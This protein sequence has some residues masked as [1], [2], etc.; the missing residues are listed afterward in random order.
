[1][2]GSIAAFLAFYYILLLSP[3]PLGIHGFKGSTL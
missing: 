2:R 3:L 1:M